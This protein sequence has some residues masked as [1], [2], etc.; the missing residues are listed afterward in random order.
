MDFQEPSHDIRNVLNDMCCYSIIKRFE[1]R[2][3]LRDRR[4]APGIVYIENVLGT[5]A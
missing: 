5:Y 2:D 4:I 1:I 3:N